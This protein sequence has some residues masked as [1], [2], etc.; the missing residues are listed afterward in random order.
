M[1]RPIRVLLVEDNPGDA[2]L[3]RDTLEAS[4]L[5]YDI[6]VAVDGEEAIEYVLQRGR[7]AA[8]ERPDLILLDLN[9][10]RLHGAE[11]LAEIKRHDA[12][13]AIPIVVFTSS[14][15]EQDILQSYQRGANGYVTKVG[16]LDGF[17]AKVQAI[18]RFWFTIVTLP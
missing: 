16:D 14:D 12:L 9:L 1:T 13:R 15:A 7:H 17:V 5:A 4:A 3:T 6:A 2:D 10:P 11:V 8:A 18:E